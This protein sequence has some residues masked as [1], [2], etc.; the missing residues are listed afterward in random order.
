MNSINK[1]KK[2][3]KK[4]TRNCFNARAISSIEKTYIS[5]NAIYDYFFIFYFLLLIFCR[6][7]VQEL[8][9]LS[10]IT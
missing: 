2:N 9:L 5:V 10:V 4:K 3:R 6:C 7:C 8:S 1:K